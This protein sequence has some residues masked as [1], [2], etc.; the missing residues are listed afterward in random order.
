MLGLTTH[1][2]QLIKRLY[3]LDESELC[4][5]MVQLQGEQHKGH[6]SRSLHMRPDA[7]VLTWRHKLNRESSGEAEET[8]SATVSTSQLI[9]R[10]TGQ[11]SDLD[12]NGQS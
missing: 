10:S 9:L 2:K 7:R 11:G 3:K 4:A 6:S 8:V 5:A 1:P 12:E